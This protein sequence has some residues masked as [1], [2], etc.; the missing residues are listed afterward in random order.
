VAR[1]PHRPTRGFTLVEAVMVIAITGVVAA[2]VASFV[3]KPVDAYVDLAR[4]AEL[5]D[6]ADG[7][8]RRIARELRTALPNSVRVD[9]TGSFIEFL[10]VRS[11][12]RYRAVQTAAGGGDILDFGSGSDASFDVLGPPVAALAG[13]QLVVHNLGLSGA[14]AY[15]GT[16]RRALTSTGAALSSL[17]YTLG[18]SQ[19]PFASPNQRFHIV[20]TPVSFVCAPVAG[21]AGTLRRY[22]GYTIQATQPASTGAAP[23]SGL[24]GDHN[25]LLAGSVSGCSF[26]YGSSS[27]ARNAVVTLRLTLTGGGESITLLQQVQVENSP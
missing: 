26:T 23:L 1:H 14:D 16:S 3:R 24:S 20:A 22:G 4:R 12:G 10:P 13:D 7:A 11:A 15:E 17:A 21:G 19:F 5:T 18:G 8:L 6:T 25:A 2:M 9:A 27:T